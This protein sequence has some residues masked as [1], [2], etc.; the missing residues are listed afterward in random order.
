MDILLF[1]LYVISLVIMADTKLKEFPAGQQFL[2]GLEN[3]TVSIL[4]WRAESD[5]DLDM[6][7]IKKVL[8]ISTI[9]LFV[10]AFIMLA[11]GFQLNIYFASIFLINFLLFISVE[12]FLD[13]KKETMRMVG[14]MVILVIS[15]WLFYFLEQSVGVPPVFIDLFKIQLSPLGLADGS[16]YE[17]LGALSVML[18]IGSSMLLGFWVITVTVP[19]VTLFWLLKVINKMSFLLVNVERQKVQLFFVAVNILVPIWF[20]A[21]DKIA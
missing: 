12:W 4:R 9:V 6:V 5:A 21:K 3:G 19:S 7:G 16:D 18:L 13:I 10:A 8:L 17:I 11:N 2:N 15:P 1:V 20:F 14:I